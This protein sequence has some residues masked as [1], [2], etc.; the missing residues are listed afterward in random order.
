M[1]WPRL[2]Q[3]APPHPSPHSSAPTSCFLIL[4]DQRMAGT[5]L[6]LEVL[7][8]PV[9]SARDWRE[10]G[11]GKFSR[12]SLFPSKESLQMKMGP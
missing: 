10:T 1:L 9:A 3:H 2:G 6:C 5:D 12:V 11:A 7:V 4:W 8:T